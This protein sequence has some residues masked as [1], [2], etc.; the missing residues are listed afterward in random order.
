MGDTLGKRLRRLRTARGYTVVELAGAVGVGE[1]TM[2]Q[3]ERGGVTS[4]AFHLGL[5]LLR[6]S[7]LIR[8]SSPARTRGS[9]NGW[10]RSTAVS[11]CWSARRPLMV[12]R[13]RGGHK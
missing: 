1:S 10:R 9:R 4:P 3:I 2:R 11:M 6:P 13:S 5:R 7:V 12:D 8:K